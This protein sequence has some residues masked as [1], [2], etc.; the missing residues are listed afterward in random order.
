MQR[1]KGADLADM[2]D[3]NGRINSAAIQTK[4]AQTGLIYGFVVG[5]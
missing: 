5:L 1:I 4:P 2:I 3:S